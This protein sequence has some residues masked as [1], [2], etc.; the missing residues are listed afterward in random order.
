M[1]P[2]AF[3]LFL[4]NSM[5]SIAALPL[6]RRWAATNVF[7]LLMAGAVLLGLIAPGPGAAD[8]TISLT[9]LTHAGVALIF[10]LHGANLAPSVLLSGIRQWRVH[11]LVQGTTYIAFPVGVGLVAL[12][13]GRLM[14]PELLLGFIFLAALPSTISSAV[15]LTGLAGGHVPVAVFNASI[16]GLIGLVLTPGI[17]A[18]V[19]AAGS[20]TVAFGPAVLSIALT[21]LLPFALGQIARPIIGGFLKQHKAVLS[22]VDRGVILLII[23][24]SFAASTAAG[25][26]STF[27]AMEMAGTFVIVSFLLAGALAFVTAAAAAFRFSQQDTSAAVFCGATKSLATGAPMAQIL[28][29]DRP[30]IG[31]ILLP[32]LLYHPLQLTVCAVVAQRRQGQTISP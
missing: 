17:I 13:P 16:S 18:L 1:R 2:D 26:W 23:Y 15:A 10:C 9:T 25:I 31:I 12:A 32:L 5:K 3:S 7:V 21:V 6:L 28:F 19:S 8:G 20:G 14:G 24:T 22:R 11:L 29:A 27:S 4:E 30:T